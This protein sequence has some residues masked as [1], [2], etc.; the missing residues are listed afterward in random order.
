MLIKNIKRLTM[1]RCE[2]TAAFKN[3]NQQERTVNIAG[4][5]CFVN[6]MQYRTCSIKSKR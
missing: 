2:K 3:V 6:D 4:W 5:I 1:R